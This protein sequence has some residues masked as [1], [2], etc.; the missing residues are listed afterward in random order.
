MRNANGHFNKTFWYE[1]RCGN[2]GINALRILD[3]PGA[4]LIGWYWIQ[5][6]NTPHFIGWKRN[7]SQGLIISPLKRYLE[8]SIYIFGHEATS[9]MKIIKKGR[10]KCQ[11][12][13]M[14]IHLSQIG[15]MMLSSLTYNMDVNSPITSMLIN[16]I[17]SMYIPC[18]HWQGWKFEFRRTI[19][20]RFIKKGINLHFEQNSNFIIYL[21][22]WIWKNVLFSSI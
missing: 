7:T 19:L 1:Q 12:D 21:N 3:S 22:A 17:T 5:E 15:M 10:A 20:M 16:P 6:R 14:F 13:T 4:N 9:E 18:L 8:P 11:T 2:V